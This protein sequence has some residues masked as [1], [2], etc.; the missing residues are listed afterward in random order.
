MLP[1]RTAI[2][3]FVSGVHLKGTLQWLM[4]ITTI[5]LH[6]LISLNLMTQNKK[7]LK[8]AKNARS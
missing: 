1:A 8:I 4:E 7:Y 5:G 2:K 3:T 6:A